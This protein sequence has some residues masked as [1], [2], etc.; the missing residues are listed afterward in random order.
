MTEAPEV[1]FTKLGEDRIAYQVLGEGPPDLLEFSSPG[2]AIEALWEYPPCAAFYRRLASFSRLIVFDRRG[3]GASDEVSLEALPKW[4]EWA[5]DALTVLDAV[6]SKRA[7]ILGEMNSG[8]AATLF[9][10]TR[11]ERTQALILFG[12]AARF[13]RAPD[14]PW[15]MTQEGLDDVASMVEEHWGTERLGALGAPSQGDNSAYLRWQAK[16]ARMG[17]SARA[18]GTF[19]RHEQKVDVREVLTSIQV[20]TLVLHREDAPFI[21]ADQGR[22]LAEHIPGARFVSI[23]GADMVMML[24]PNAQTLDEIEA[25]VSESGPGQRTDRTLAA[26]LFT[27]IVGSTERAATLGDRRWRSLMESHDAIAHTLIDQ[28]GGRLVRLTGDG[29]LATFDGP[30]R[31]IKC[32]FAVRDALDPLGLTIRAGLHTGEVELLGDEIGG[33]G[34]HVA[35]RVL[36]RAGPAELVVSAAVPMLVAGSGIEFEDRGE[37]ELKGI[38]G[39][40]RLYAVEG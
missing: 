39:T 19:M 4:E 21:V 38:P 23:P 13:L 32:A 10:A 6:G 9:A 33:I 17:C 26:V 12:T 20:P 5:D 14:Y 40:W 37:H 18:M 3:T 29:V 22:H 35:A 24:K 27:D 1:R 34:V 15:G 11:P 16:T 28:H 30:G 7:V 31:A 8:P 25:F 36:E 2:G